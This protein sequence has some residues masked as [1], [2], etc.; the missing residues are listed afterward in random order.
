[1][2]MNNAPGGTERPGIKTD[3]PNYKHLHG[4]LTG[5]GESRQG[6][7]RELTEGNRIVTDQVNKHKKQN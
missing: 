7:S 5:T 2:N 3:E 1:M 6:R 4:K